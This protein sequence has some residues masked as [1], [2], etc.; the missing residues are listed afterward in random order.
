[1][2]A[3]LHCAT[4]NPPGNRYC[5]GCGRAL[6]LSCSSCGERM[7]PDARFCG[8]CGT[9]AQ[10]PRP[11]GTASDEA[12]IKH[13]TV[14]FADIVSSTRLIADMD[15]E[16]SLQ[17]L[18]PVVASM[19][20]AVVRHGG[21]I[22]R[23]LGDGLMALFGAPQAH[24]GHA[25]L[26]CETALALHA[27]V[28]EFEGIRLRIGMHSGEVAILT[29][30]EGI[31]RDL[32]LHG[33]AIH[34]ANRVV[35]MADAGTTFM[36]GETLALA[37]SQYDAEL[38]GIRQAQGFDAPVRL[39]RLVGPKGGASRESALRAGQTVLRGRAAEMARL[40]EA[41]RAAQA[42]RSR[43][44]GIVGAP[45]SG[46]SRLCAEFADE[47]RRRQV[48]VLEARAQL[49][50]HATPL[51]P[52][53]EFLR[54]AVIRVA[55]GDDAAAVRWRVA[56]LVQTMGVDSPQDRALVN[57]FLGVADDTGATQGLSAKARRSRLL[58]LVGGM[59]RH[60]VTRQPTVIL[61]ED[62]H[63][64]DEASAE[65]FAALVDSV[66][67]TPT[68]L[69]VNY[70]PGCRAPWMARDS[71]SEI[72][73]SELLQEDMVA[74]VEQLIGE[75][76]ETHGLAL[77]IAQR[78]GGNP[79]FAE[80][81]VRALVADGTLVGSPSQR[82]LG[83]ELGVDAND[84]PL[85]ATLQ[86]VIGGRIDQLDDAAK[87][88]LQLCA[89]VGKDFPLGVLQFVIGISPVELRRRLDALCAAEFLA[90]PSRVNFD[91]YSFRHPLIQEVAYQTQLKRKR[92]PLHAEV[93]RA[94]ESFY[95]NVG[96][97][98]AGLV[99][100]H[101]EA[102]GLL[103]EAAGSLGRAAVWISGTDTAQALRNWQHVRELLLEQ[104]DER[105]IGVL[106]SRASTQIALLAWRE[107]IPVEQV[108]PL[109]DEAL[110]WAR[111]HDERMVPMLLF[112]E[113]RNHIASGGSA[114][115][116]VDCMQQALDIA[117]GSDPTGRRAILNTALS[118]A[119]GWA[120]L[121]REALAASDA[122]LADIGGADAGA[123]FLGY[124]TE[125]WALN[126]RGRILA[127][128]GRLDE[129][130]DCFE[131]M[132]SIPHG[133]L[134]PTVRFIAHM[135]SLEIALTRTDTSRAQGH[136]LQVA[137]IAQ[138]QPNPYLRMFALAAQGLS[139]GI[140][141]DFAAAL[142]AYGASLDLLRAS[143]VAMEYETELLASVCECHLA[144]GQHEAAARVARETVEIAR[145]RATRLPE[146]RAYLVLAAVAEA[147]G[148]AS[149]H[150]S[151]AEDLIR[152]TGVD[153]H[154]APLRDMD[155][156]APCGSS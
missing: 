35:S 44:V 90:T 16:Q 47:C 118:Q 14:L 151:R 24:E 75:R 51:Q 120:G 46:K 73:V 80:E 33:V 126:L 8:A 19:A 109:L 96:D 70:R 106:R 21:I 79:F 156:P 57:E 42:G 48:P 27:A 103:L 18:A 140:A 100:F 72:A 37:A 144:L 71:F 110:A 123:Q 74:L 62:L 23:T 154:F 112:L 56:A 92:K 114:D 136:A 102:A 83:V 59:V 86:A 60:V 147:P 95:E 36:T 22:G 31:E 11:L 3:C 124:R 128:M 54:S 122:A 115:F 91:L 131:K 117:A 133:D 153:I 82:Q 58:A 39:H 26:A 17:F 149:D 76:P 93:A 25:V 13:A 119:Y 104:P 99:A 134:D 101:Y 4:L 130:Q 9:P 137:L 85:P 142:V 65:F 113:G 138:Q 146:C 43:I 20:Q 32:L 78:S 45:G 135:G 29:R 30:A 108:K 98:F 97:E 107:G 53:L 41:Q 125:Y 28:A 5:F 69:A 121:L 49:Y 87:S 105:E 7:P 84:A 148:E 61:I 40:N 145:A 77:R 81:M 38:V 15:A 12:E 34:L 89:I 152:R 6:Q 94:M 50:G 55:P 116:Y 141:G 111:R 155:A 1:M 129:A 88:L 64:M 139:H 63:W 66:A 68:L 67:D 132:L 150:L 143:R 2:R 10:R 127:R 52:V